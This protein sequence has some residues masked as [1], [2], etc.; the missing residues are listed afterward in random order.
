MSAKCLPDKV[1]KVDIKTSRSSFE[2]QKYLLF[3]LYDH[4]QQ[5][6][7]HSTQSLILLIWEKKRRKNFTLLSDNLTRS[8]RKQHKQRI[9]RRYSF[10][11]TKILSIT[12][13]NLC[14][15]HAELNAAIS[16]LQV[17]PFMPIIHL[18]LYTYHSPRNIIST[19]AWKLRIKPSFSTIFTT[20]KAARKILLEGT[21]RRRVF[22]YVYLHK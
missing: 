11:S 5:L 4:T 1:P 9:Y 6:A 7:H 19:M 12:T 22:D 13:A 20:N 17:Q 18:H 15:I 16:R 8:S 21:P 3:P 2:F 14:R 10:C